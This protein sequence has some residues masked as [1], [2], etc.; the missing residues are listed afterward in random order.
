MSSPRSNAVW[1]GRG[2]VIHARMS[3][4]M[5]STR[6][7]AGTSCGSSTRRSPN[8]QPTGSRTQLLTASGSQSD[9]PA[10]P[11]KLHSGWL[12]PAR[13]PIR[14]RVLSSMASISGEPLG[15]AVRKERAAARRMRL[16]EPGAVVGLV[17]PSSGRSS[18]T[19]QRSPSRERDRADHRSVEIDNEKSQ[20]ATRAPQAPRAQAH[21]AVEDPEV[22]AHLWRGPQLDERTRSA[23]SVGQRSSDRTARSRSC[24]R[25]CSASLGARV[26]AA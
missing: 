16:V 22:G 3:S 21:H 9:R 2:P 10:R 20:G 18:L 5:S 25:R 17:E 19:G 13:S 23:S 1:N 12:D 11:S 8:L 26:T 24:R 14:I 6:G 15:Q 4:V 7:A